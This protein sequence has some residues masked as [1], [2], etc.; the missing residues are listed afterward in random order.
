VFTS[1]RRNLTATPHQEVI[2]TSL[3]DVVFY[4]AWMKDDIA[5]Y[6]NDVI[7]GACSERFV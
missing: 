6:L 3:G 2:E 1:L 5:I 4:E 7:A